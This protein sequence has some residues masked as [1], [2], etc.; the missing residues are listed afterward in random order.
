MANLTLKKL[1]IMY[2][3]QAS[4]KNKNVSTLIAFSISIHGSA[5]KINI[6]SVTQFILR[7]SC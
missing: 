4:I 2:N 3:F 1:A 7:E 5:K 6:L